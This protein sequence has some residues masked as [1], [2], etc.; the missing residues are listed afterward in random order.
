M[1]DFANTL[2]KIVVLPLRKM[3]YMICSRD[4][5]S[6]KDLLSAPCVGQ[7][8]PSGKLTRTK[9]NPRVNS[10]GFFFFL[11]IGGAGAVPTSE[12]PRVFLQARLSVCQSLL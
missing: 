5:N 11:F 1:V 3:K 2:V 4:S 7:R 6:Y 9:R 8:L 10:L 12:E